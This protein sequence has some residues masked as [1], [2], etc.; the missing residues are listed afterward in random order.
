MWLGIRVKEKKIRYEGIRKEVEESKSQAS[1][2]RTIDK[3][4]DR[5]EINFDVKS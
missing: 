5:R 2:E 3:A 4:K 1:I